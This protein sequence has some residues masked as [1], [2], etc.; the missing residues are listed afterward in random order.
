L[1][2]ELSAEGWRIARILDHLDSGLVAAVAV[3]DA[4]LVEVLGRDRV[5]F[6]PDVLDPGEY[7]SV[8]PRT[9]PG[10]NV[11]L[12]GAAHHRKN[13]FTQ[14]AAFEL[15]RRSSGGEKLTLH[16]NGQSAQDA[17]LRSFLVSLPVRYVEHGFL[18]RADYLS[19]V[20]G[21]DAGLCATLSESYCYVAADH[22]SLGVPV[23]TS[24]AVA[25]VGAGE[26]EAG[27]PAA[28]EAVAECLR[29]ALERPTLIEVAKRSLEERATANLECARAG[30]ARLREL[31]GLA[32]HE[33]GAALPGRHDASA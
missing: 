26:L 13:H 32:E 7:R 27:D 2:S 29:L 14:A 6:L 4:A 30:L 21:M 17:D 11:S 20:A 16:L 18:A 9:F 3:N 19:V 10:G 15:V 8:T 5:V 31:A 28:A 1:Q 25:C 24:P 23:V 12:F 33:L 22:I